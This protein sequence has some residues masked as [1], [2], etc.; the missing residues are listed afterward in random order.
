VHLKTFKVEPNEDGKESYKIAK[1]SIYKDYCKCCD[2]IENQK[3][4]LKK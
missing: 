3:G 2:M 1:S 4:V